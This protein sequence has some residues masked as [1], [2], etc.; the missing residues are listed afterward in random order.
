[1][2]QKIKSIFSKHRP[3]DE[4]LEKRIVADTRFWIIRDP[5][6][7]ATRRILALN[8]KVHEATLSMTNADLAAIAE[9][10]L[11]AANKGDVSKCAFLFHMMQTQLDLYCTER[12]LF[13]ISNCIVLI[14]GEPF[15]RMT[16]S[17]TSIKQHLFDTIPEVKS[18]FFNTAQRFLVLMSMLSDDTD[19]EA[20]LKS[21]QYKSTDDLFTAWLRT[22]EN[23]GSYTSK[24][25]SKNQT[26]S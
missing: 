5:L 24:K 9:S 17:H 21:R 18:F 2:I 1:M 12:T 20:F 22:E 25:N 16:R 11:E 8:N 7:H 13:T 10:G 15:D 6:F 19:V 3:P 26:S 4:Y 23:C 14:D